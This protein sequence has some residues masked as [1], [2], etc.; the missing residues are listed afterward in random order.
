MSARQRL[1]TE[2]R[3]SECACALDFERLSGIA[4]W[5][6]QVGTLEELL[7]PSM[8]EKFLAEGTPTVASLRCLQS[9]MGCNSEERVVVGGVPGLIMCSMIKQCMFFL[10]D[11]GE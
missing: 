3:Q 4:E 5:C 11:E 2:Y 9:R 7:L 1:H 6:E 8:R 10:V